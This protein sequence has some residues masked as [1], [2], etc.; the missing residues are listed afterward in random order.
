MTRALL[1]ADPEP[2]VSTYLARHLTDDG[3]AVVRAE[4]GD[5]VCDLAERSRPH[6]VILGDGAEVC[7][8][9]RD[10]EPGRK[11]DRD[12]PV[13]VLGQPHAD[14]V[15]RVR[16]FDKGA[17]DYVQRPFVYEELLARVHAVLR[18]TS[19]P[20]GRVLRAGELTID[21]DSLS[22]S[23]GGRRLA[24]SRKEFDLLARLAVEPTHVVT[25]EVL[26]RDI[27]GYRSVTRTRT[28]DSHA[29]RLRRKISELT[30]TPYVLNVWGRG[31]RLMLA[32]AA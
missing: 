29:S 24:L 4:T 16:A 10:G 19:P 13:I 3:F 5:A 20:P 18:R 26:L 8:R 27:W 17:D 1:I 9:L 28:L 30:D 7:R 22:A 21:R 25:R 11:W 31:Y 14:P 32:A 2:S 6:L 23:I 12:V 15:D